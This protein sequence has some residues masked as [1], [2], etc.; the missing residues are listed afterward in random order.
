MFPGRAVF[1]VARLAPGSWCTTGSRPCH[2]R[3]QSRKCTV[4]INGCVCQHVKASPSAHGTTPTWPRSG[5]TRKSSQRTPHACMHACTRQR[6]CDCRPPVQVH[7]NRSTQCRARGVCTGCRGGGARCTQHT[8][9]VY[10]CFAGPCSACGQWRMAHF[11]VFLA[12]AHRPTMRSKFAV[13]VTVLHVV[14]SPDVFSW[15]LPSR[16]TEQTPFCVFVAPERN[17]SDCGAAPLASVHTGCATHLT[18]LKYWSRLQ[19][20]FSHT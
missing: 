12:P 5:R 14:H 3:R 17:N 11:K 18:P 4:V 19:P 6:L 10:A 8:H 9:K 7:Y 13:H 2:G 1:V 20:F 16:H 15:Y